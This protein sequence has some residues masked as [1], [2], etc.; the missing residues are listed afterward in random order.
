[1]RL[2]GKET[3]AL[4][5]SPEAERWLLASAG[6]EVLGKKVI[7]A[8]ADEL[9]ANGD[10]G[11]SPEGMRE[12]KETVAPPYIPG[13]WNSPRVCSKNNCYNY[14]CNIQTNTFAQP[15][16][17]HGI[18]I[19]PGKS[20]SVRQG[21]ERDGLIFLGGTY[22][23]REAPTSHFAALAIWPGYDFH[24]WRR[25]ANGLW[26]HKPGATPVTNHDNSGNL[27]QQPHTCDRG[28]YTSFVGYFEVFP[29]VSII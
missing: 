19:D 14:G 11:H 4:A 2:G 25:D 24:W 12:A 7:T 23:G 27:I 21:A 18:T 6:E 17:R 29:N 10:A 3:L 1:M 5:S 20:A 8:V 15:G 9:D 28:A 13:E 22:P 26:S 16:R